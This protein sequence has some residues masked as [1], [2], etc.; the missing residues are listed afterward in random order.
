MALLKIQQL[1]KRFGGVSVFNGLDMA[2]EQGEIRCIIGPNGTGKT[3]LFNMITGRLRPDSGKILFSEQNVVNLK[4][5]EINRLGISRKFQAPSV[6]EDMTVWNNLM[7]AGTGHSN[8]RRLFTTRPDA[9]LQERAEHILAS[10]R[11]NDQRHT[12]AGS[13][14]HGQK[15]WLEIGIV[16]LNEP[17]LIL[18]DEPTAGMT[19]AETAE[20]ADL[21]LDIF[22]DRTAIIIEHDISFVRR[23][24]GRVTVL[25][26][27]GVMCEGSFDDVAANEAVRRVYLGEE[28]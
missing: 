8:A 11:L 22:K 15:Q 4:V 25:Y 12:L 6:F 5:H 23:L 2:V 3:T 10:V 28:V 21:I 20:T 14:S 16:L 18:L 24:N 9:Q 17:Q 19:L 13:L 27:G 26:R 1:C 7:I